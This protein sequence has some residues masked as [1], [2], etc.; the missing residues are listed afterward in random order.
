M[1]SQVFIDGKFYPKSKA[2]VSVF[3]HGLLYGDGIFEGI[4]VYDGIIFK[5]DQH[6]DR[7]YESAKTIMLDLTQSTSEMKELCAECVRKN[8]LRDAYI[9]LIVTRGIGDLGLDPRKCPK[10]TVIIIAD[11]ITLYPESFYKNGLEVATVATTRNMA[12]SLNP[13]IKSLNYLNN[14]MGKIE[15]NQMG[16]PEG[17]MLNA[18]GF[19]SEATADNI[20]IVK[21]KTLRTPPTYDG[22]LEGITRGTILDIGQ[23]LGY[24]CEKKT[25]TRHDLYNS[26]ECFL[27]GTA[28]ELIP[29]VG[30]DGRRINTGRPGPIFKKLLSEF[31]KIT[32]IDGYDAYKRLDI[33]PYD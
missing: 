10:P 19:V 26:D 13:K 21:N 22:A 24:I 23:K 17:I 18:N 32:K 5:L 27:T 28:A 14:I 9:R 29:V 30:I 7:L 1:E 11:K 20:F 15:A 12:D 31:R 16:C 33:T 8:K 6:L 2:M 3:D 25:L 4:R